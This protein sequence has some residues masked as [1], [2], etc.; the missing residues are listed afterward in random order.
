M[1]EEP[2]EPLIK[3]RLVA[4]LILLTLPGAISLL[5]AANHGETAILGMLAAPIAGVAA[6][7]LL[8]LDWPKSLGVKL[9]VGAGLALA[10]TLVAAALAF[11]GCALALY[12][13]HP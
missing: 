12:R 3:S 1:S 4:V 11:L 2:T 8:I 6:A 9:L 13:P 7:T 5:A 10:F